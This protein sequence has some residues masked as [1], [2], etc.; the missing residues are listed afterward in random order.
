M[1]VSVVIPTRDRPDLL[2]LTLQTVL[3]QEASRLK[4]WSSMTVKNRGRPNW[5]AK[6]E[7]VGC[8]CFETAIPTE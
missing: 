5:F 4:F 3:W 8:G 6:W 2:A 1:D 7:T